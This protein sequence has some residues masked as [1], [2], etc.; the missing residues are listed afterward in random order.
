MTFKVIPVAVFLLPAVLAGC[1][2]SGLPDSISTR[3]KFSQKLAPITMEF[4][5]ETYEIRRKEFQGDKPS[6]T[7]EAWAIIVDGTAYSCNAPS[8]AA[9]EIALKRAA[10]GEKESGGGMGY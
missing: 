8:R 2:D 9:C 4:D 5:G 1:G 6:D 10:E 3:Y 7:Y